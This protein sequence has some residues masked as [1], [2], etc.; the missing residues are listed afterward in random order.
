[1][2]RTLAALLLLVASSVSGDLG[3]KQMP[4]P[5]EIQEYHNLK[6]GDRMPSFSIDEYAPL[7]FG[8]LFNKKNMGIL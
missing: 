4:P 5:R 8:E 7:F 3:L 6:A 2:K 1:M